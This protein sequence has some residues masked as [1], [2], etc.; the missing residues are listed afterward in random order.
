MDSNHIS[1]ARILALGVTLTWQEAVAVTKEAARMRA[2]GAA[3]DDNPPLVSAEECYIGRRGNLELPT[4]SDDE[5][6]EALGLLLRLLLS[7]RDAP[8]ALRALAVDAA[9]P[10]MVEALGQFHVA[11]HHA[12]IAKLAA[13]ALDHQSRAGRQPVS[14]T[15]AVPVAILPSS[16]PLE[17]ETSR[18]LPV[19]ALPVPLVSVP[20]M[21]SIERRADAGATAA[22]ERP[23]AGMSEELM[24]LRQKGVDIAARAK[25]AGGAGLTVVSRRNAL[26]AASVLTVGVMASAAWLLGGTGSTSPVAEQEISSVP[27]LAMTLVGFSTPVTQRP[28]DIRRA[29]LS[30]NPTVA[31][32][33]SEALTTPFT[34]VASVDADTI[35]PLPLAAST[36]RASALMISTPAD[37]RKDEFETSRRA[38]SIP[39]AVLRPTAE[40]LPSAREPTP[41]PGLRSEVPYPLSKPVAS[42]PAAEGP[43]PARVAPDNR[44]DDD[45]ALFSADD[46]DVS[47]P[48]LRRQQLPSAVL[49][50]SAEIPEGWPYL[51]LVVDQAGLVESVRLNARPPEPGQSLY[52]HR[53]LLAAAKSW[54][55]VPARKDG[56]PV[57][58]QVRVP[59]EP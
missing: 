39:G 37:P 6:P 38:D 34:I 35:A 13:R 50:P 52:R 49:E 46:R 33:P 32:T 24:R 17:I 23:V 25:A 54:Q 53:M 20:R 27:S 47:P 4:T 2:V 1:I 44:L 45:V 36:G 57:R 51:M 58:Y 5:S 41:A 31:L 40:R 59:L 42:A 15:P 29:A 8:E 10:D 16:P 55:F 43:R 18:P 12:E 30:E 56:Q 26:V 22:P 19:P 11:D 9:P 14:G 7:G 21:S 3:M 28:P 48:R